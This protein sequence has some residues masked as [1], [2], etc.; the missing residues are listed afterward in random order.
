MDFQPGDIAACFGTAPISRLI[1]WATASPLLRAPAGLRLG[2][3]HV[4]I[5]AFMGHRTVWVEST[6]LCER[7]C[8]V[9][10]ER[11]V[12]C[13][14]HEPADR[15]E[16]YLAEGGSVLLFRPTRL[17]RFN[18]QDRRELSRLLIND[19]V[20]NETAY[21]TRGALLSGSHVLQRLSCFGT[22]NLTNLFCSEKI[23]AVLQRFGRLWS[24][25]HAG[26][27]NPGT[28]MRW[29]VR[30]GVYELVGPLEPPRVRIYRGVGDA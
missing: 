23:A 29:L 12:G 13:Q 14:V 26:K 3:S 25:K 1:S 11:V 4:A 7:I 19:F 6:S 30:M 22:A 21:D 27:F 15:V 10:G 2:P 20:R 9:R 18:P 16:D 8:L 17:W 24:D 5:G 28:L